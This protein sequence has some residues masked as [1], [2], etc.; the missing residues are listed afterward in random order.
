MT[1]K[2]GIRQYNHRGG[3]PP[4][5]ADFKTVCDAVLEAWNGSG[6]TVTEVAERFEV[7]R[8]WIYKWVYPTLHARRNGE[9]E[10]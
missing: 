2:P 4:L 6:E 9:G 1:D 5:K 8:G 7:S 10:S 3:R